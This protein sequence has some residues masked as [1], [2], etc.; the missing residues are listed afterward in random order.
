MVHQEMGADPLNADPSVPVETRPVHPLLAEVFAALDAA[1][2]GWCLLRGEAGLASPS[3]D[4]DMMVDPSQVRAMEE[5][6]APLGV[7]PVERWGGGLHRYFLGYHAPTD[8]WIDLDVEP[9]FVYGPQASFLVNW[10]LPAL[11]TRV[12]AGCLAR[13]RQEGGIWVLDRDDAFWALLAHCV[14]DK[15]SVAE[16]HRERLSELAASASASGEFGTVVGRNSPPGWDAARIIEAA[17]AG[18]W[19]ELVAVGAQLPRRATAARP[20]STRAE[21]LLRGLGRLPAT[22][23][24]MRHAGF[25]VAILGPDG[26]GKSTLSSGIVANFG[27][28]AS[29]VYMGLW[30]GEEGQRR[31]LVRAGLAAANRPLK[32]WR[33]YLVSRYHR[34]RGQLVIFDRHVYDALLPPEPPLVWAK[35]LFFGFLAHAAP[36]PHLVLVL[37]LPSE[38][39]MQRRPE[40]RPEHLEALRAQYRALAERLGRAQLMPAAGT[41]DEMRIDATDRIWRAYVARRSSTR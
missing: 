18:S 9:E 17:A 26:A 8:Q 14:V 41:P 33:R 40:E 30:Q 32:V 23:W 38:V 29:L 1:E 28:P 3:G 35:R 2:I 22:A 13:R 31:S 20:V 6:L 5:A 37:D 11:R 24:R 4:I 36:G 27:L 15:G 16:R 34:A 39:T 19:D 7:V 12:A 21:A 10:M 25:S